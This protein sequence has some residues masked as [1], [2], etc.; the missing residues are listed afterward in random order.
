MLWRH[1]R[2]SGI[3]LAAAD[4]LIHVDINK[5]DLNYSYPVL[6]ELA[7]LGSDAVPQDVAIKEPSIREVRLT[8]RERVV[9]KALASGMSND[10]IATKLFISSDTVKFHLKGLFRKLGVQSR[11]QAMAIVAGA[12]VLV[13]R[14]RTSEQGSTLPQPS[15]SS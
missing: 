10:A 2:W 11:C 5:M 1:S 8:R 6:L 14:Q 3:R 9:L 15:T 13:A 12:Q 7:S 4:P